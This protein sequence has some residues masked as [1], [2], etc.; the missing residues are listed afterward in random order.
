M[1]TILL[2]KSFTHA[3]IPKIKIKT[4][5]PLNVFNAFMY[6]LFQVFSKAL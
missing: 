1:G 5:S 2:M 3:L 6:I 4:I